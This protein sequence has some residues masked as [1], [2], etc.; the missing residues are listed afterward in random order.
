MIENNF[1]P[2]FVAGIVTKGRQIGRTLA[3]PTANIIP[4]NG[5]MPNIPYGVYAGWTIFEKNRYA[6]IMSFG[7]AETV[8]AKDI[9]LETHL[10]DYEGDLYGKEL[11]VE[12]TLFLRNMTKFNSL[13]ELK[14]AM[15]QDENRARKLLE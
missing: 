7:K 6:S 2:V 3:Y 4:L 10:L 1:L 13:E 12:V 9:A 8:G 15:E 5:V 11:K 14:V